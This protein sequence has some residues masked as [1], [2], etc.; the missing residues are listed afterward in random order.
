MAARRVVIFSALYMPHLGGVEK[1]SQSIAAELSTDCEVTVFCMNTESRP[2]FVKEGSVS[3]YY[4][5]CVPMQKGRFPVP[6]P[7]A[8]R[9]VREWFEANEADFAIVQCRFYL[10]SEWA[11]RF[12][13]KKG[14]RYI[15]IEHGAGDVVMPNKLVDFIWHTYEKALTESEK[16]FPHEWFGVSQ[17]SIRWLKHYGITGRGVISN[18]VKP[19]DFTD[20]LANRGSWRREHGIPEDALIISFS[21]RIMVDKGILEL[22]QA[23]DRLRGDD[24]HLVIAGGGDMDLLEP[25]QGRENIHIL[26]QVDFKDIPRIMV[27]SQI[28][29]LPSRFIEGQPT[30]LLEAGYCGCAVTAT[31]NGGIT[32]V[33]PSEEYGLLIQTGDVDGLTEALQSLIDDPEKR[34]RLGANLQARVREHYTWATA[35]A[36]IRAVMDEYGL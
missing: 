35:A 11:V 8:Y 28:F 10:L 14:I 22:T 32:E 13:A 36:K 33:I 7:A 18:S 4:L 20:A 27:D 30:S 1:F 26:G 6:K 19:A 2:E 15:Q 9:R 34:E 24:L 5:P 3:V 17:A 12:L 29:C 31:A 16:R 23:F 21:G 25:W